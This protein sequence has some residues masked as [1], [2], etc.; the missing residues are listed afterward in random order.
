MRAAWDP[1]YGDRETELVLTGLHLDPDA[2]TG[3]LEACLLT[4]GELA[5]GTGR[6]AG[7]A[8]PVLCPLNGRR[9]AGVESMAKC[10]VRVV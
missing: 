8:R 7:D 4:D 2:I 6:L 3:S 5:Q 1:Y 9:A 10:W